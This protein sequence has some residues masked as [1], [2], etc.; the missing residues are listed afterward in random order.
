MLSTDGVRRS[1][2]WVMG[3]TILILLLALAAFQFSTT[4][5][6][7]SPFEI[8]SPEGEELGTAVLNPMD[9]GVEVVLDVDEFDPEARN[10]RVVITNV[11]K[12]REPERVRGL[13]I[14][15]RLRATE[16]EP[17]EDEMGFSAVT[18]AVT[19]DELDDE[20]GSALYLVDTAVREIIGCAV[21][22]PAA[23][24]AREATPERE[25]TPTGTATR[26]AMDNETA[27][28]E[29]VGAPNPA[30]VTAS[31]D[32]RWILPGPRALDPDVFG[33]PDQPLGLEEPIG[34]P[35]EQRRVSSDGEAFTTTRGPTA[36]SDQGEPIS[37]TLRAD[38]VDIT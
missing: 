30:M 38:V 35:L 8:R 31:G 6:Q 10:Q 4:H 23:Q 28:G 22:F 16:F 13:D 9:D 19:L 1:R 25:P 15:T 36:H 20:E 21:I 14:I 26:A 3:R 11:G 18:E 12:C 5:A 29:V 27:P 33:T 34:V 7:E 32:V 24:M 17:A 2:L 37:G